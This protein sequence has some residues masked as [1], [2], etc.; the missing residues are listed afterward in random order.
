MMKMMTKEF[1]VSLKKKE[2]YTQLFK[3]PWISLAARSGKENIFSQD[4]D[5]LGMTFKI[6][7]G[8]LCHPIK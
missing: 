4:V 3:A 7:K 1:K 6:G 8:Q 2:K 5:L